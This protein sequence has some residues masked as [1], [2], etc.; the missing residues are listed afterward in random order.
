MCRKNE[1]GIGKEM[2]KFTSRLI[3]SIFLLTAV[4]SV[5]AEYVYGACNS[6]GDGNW[7][8][9]SS[10]STCSGGTPTTTSDSATIGTGD[11]VITGNEQTQVLT[12]AEGGTLFIDCNASLA[13][14]EGGGISTTLTNHG[15]LTVSGGALSI[16][17]F[18]NFF[19]SGTFTNVI[20]EGGSIQE[21]SSICDLLVGGTGVPVNTL[22][23][24]VAGTQANVGWLSLAIVGIIAAG[25]GIALKKRS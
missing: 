19:N 22:S 16:F 2:A 4:G 10:W 15:A 1:L 12:V 6:I 13:V 7:N 5:S 23:L 8:N 3:I 17:T 25:A 11:I 24:L 20:E 9:P 18:G 21:I 14:T